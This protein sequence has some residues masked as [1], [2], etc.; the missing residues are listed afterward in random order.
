MDDEADFMP[1]YEDY[2]N[3]ST[4]PSKGKWG[5]CENAPSHHAHGER[6]I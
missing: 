3:Q 5:M 6:K 1:D 2:Q 4:L